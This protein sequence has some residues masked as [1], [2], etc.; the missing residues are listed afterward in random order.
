MAWATERARGGEGGGGGGDDRRRRTIIFGKTNMII[1]VTPI[2]ITIGFI[3]ICDHWKPSRFSK[4]VGLAT[5]GSSGSGNGSGCRL[6][7]SIAR[8]FPEGVTSRRTVGQR[9][10]VS[11]TSSR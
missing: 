9:L 7:D 1:T 5:S 6:C 11:S 10:C 4:K 2:I 3:S 8:G